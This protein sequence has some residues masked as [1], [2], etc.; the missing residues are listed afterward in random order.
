MS[1]FFNRFDRE[2]RHRQEFANVTD[3]GRKTTQYWNAKRKLLRNN[4]YMKYRGEGYSF[5]RARRIAKIKASEII[6]SSMKH[7][8]KRRR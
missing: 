7:R 8:E 5:F 4:L 3:V 1:G 2:T 6:L